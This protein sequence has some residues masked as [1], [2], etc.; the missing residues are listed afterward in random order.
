MEIG[1]ASNFDSDNELEEEFPLHFDSDLDRSDSEPLEYESEQ[2]LD[3]CEADSTEK[4]EFIINQKGQQKLYAGGFGFHR[5][6]TNG[7]SCYWQC[8]FY[9]TGCSASA[10]T[11]KLDDGKSS[12]A[13][14]IRQL[15]ELAESQRIADTQIDLQEGHQNSREQEVVYEDAEYL[16]EATAYELNGDLFD[17]DGYETGDDPEMQVAM[18]S[19]QYVC[20]RCRRTCKNQRGLKVHEASCRKKL[21]ID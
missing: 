19:E 21:R 1:E 13:A 12:V 3:E 17:D 15:Q 11:I 4:F 18:V 8:E 5:R 7:P 6:R 14:T 9:K 2:S 20:E 16:E 10:T